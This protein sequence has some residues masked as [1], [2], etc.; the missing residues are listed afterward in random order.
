MHPSTL[1]LFQA[2]AHVKGVDG[3]QEPGRVATLLGESPATITNWKARGVS[4]TGT[5]KA[6][7]LFGINPTWVTSEEGE[8]LT[9]VTT[10]SVKWSTTPE[11][12]AEFLAAAGH[13]P[14]IS[15]VTAGCWADIADPYQPGVAEDD[16]WLPCPARHSARTYCLRVRG[17]SMLNPGGSP[18]YAN[19]D[20]I[21]VDPDREAKPGDR[22]VVR[23]DDHQEATFKQLVL[24]DG[25]MLLK[26][27]N[28]EWT[29][30]YIE[31]NGHATITGV[32]IGKW[33]PE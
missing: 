17:E 4:K 15:W 5:L 32:V 20:I 33:V 2:I 22:V 3:R 16:V 18:S 8:M 6:H 9:S 24:E 30:R 11:D 25:R 28:P 14:L 10:N 29:P 13:V 21:F 12:H 1:R 27:L 7:A 19:G 26:A 23:M 31:V